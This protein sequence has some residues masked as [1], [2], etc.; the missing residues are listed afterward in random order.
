MLATQLCGTRP[1]MNPNAF[2]P[3]FIIILVIILFA[4]PKELDQ[5]WFRVTSKY[6][7]I[8]GSKLQAG[9]C[10][11]TKILVEAALRHS[12][13]YDYEVTCTPLKDK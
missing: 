8:V 2:I 12:Q 5:S 9:E 11:R 4:A 13:E 10:N 7:L 1:Q 3:M 6:E